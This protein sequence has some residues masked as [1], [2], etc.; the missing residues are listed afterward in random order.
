MGYILSG[1]KS[2]LLRQ[3]SPKLLPTAR[4]KDELSLHDGC[5]LLKSQVQV[6]KS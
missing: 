1:Y 2:G 3:G 4:K 6:L 5:L